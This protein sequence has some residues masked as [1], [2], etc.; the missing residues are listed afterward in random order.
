MRACRVFAQTVTYVMYDICGAWFIVTDIKLF[1]ILI[2][3]LG[4]NSHYILQV[5]FH[6]FPGKLA[7]AQ[8]FKV[9]EH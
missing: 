2:K 5:L 9:K 8:Q 1:L 4:N 6:S 7:K 3:L